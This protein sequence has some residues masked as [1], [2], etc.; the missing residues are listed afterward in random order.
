MFQGTS[1]CGGSNG[2]LFF[3]RNPSEQPKKSNIKFPRIG[4]DMR[5]TEGVIR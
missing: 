2:M 4:A 5:V 1:E 3:A